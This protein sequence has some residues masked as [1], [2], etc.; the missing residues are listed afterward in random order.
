M[1]FGKPSFPTSLEPARNVEPRLDHFT[2]QTSKTSSATL[3]LGQLLPLLKLDFVQT[4][5]RLLNFEFS[6]I[7]TQQQLQHTEQHAHRELAHLIERPF[8]E[9][10]AEACA[11]WTEILVRAKGERE[12]ADS[13][14]G[15]QQEEKETPL[16]HP[17]AIPA[18]TSKI[19]VSMATPTLGQFLNQVNGLIAARN[20]SKLADWLVLEPPFG[21]T[22]V[23]MIE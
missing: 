19:T 12:D 6:P 23:Q 1:S 9:V 2:S 8:L 16:Y 21:P 4:Q 11:I 15:E 5:L 14:L 20:E 17:P 18:H 7:L 13:I 22:Y 3:L 10:W